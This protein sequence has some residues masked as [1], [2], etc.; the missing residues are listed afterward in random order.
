MI[1]DIYEGVVIVIYLGCMLQIIPAEKAY[2]RLGPP[3]P[4]F[5]PTRICASAA[6]RFFFSLSAIL[7]VFL[8]PVFQFAF[9]YLINVL[10]HA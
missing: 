10:F 8:S 6:F 2:L 4:K 9:Q 5:L 1:A 7:E 3:P